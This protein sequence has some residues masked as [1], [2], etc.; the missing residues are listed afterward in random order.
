[1]ESQLLPVLPASTGLHLNDR[2]IIGI[3]S[4][5]LSVYM[6]EKFPGNYTSYVPASYVKYI[7][8][9]G[10]RV[11]PIK[12]NRT[13]SY[14]ENLVNSVNGILFP[15]GAASFTAIGGYSAAAWELYHHAILKN[16][17]GVYF[18]VWGTCLGFE[19]LTYLAA[20]REDIRTDCEADNVAMPLQFKPGYN[21]SRLYANASDAI[22]KI[23]TSENVTA[24]FH[25]F[26]ITEANLT[27]AKLD[28]DWRVTAVNKDTQGLEFVSSFEHKQYPIYGVQFHPEKNAYEWKRTNNNPHTANAILVQQYF[29]NFFVNEARKNSH[30]FPSPEEEDAALIY[31]YQATYTGQHGSAFEQCYFFTD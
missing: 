9:A 10:A 17:A 21:T 14:Y 23:L 4:Q 27:Q 8:A 29:A 22:L 12:I 24:N 3:L 1:M 30:Q 2:P 20:Q 5:E 31:N 26:C 13:A 15:G 19:L 18:P 25:H 11:V 28:S 16:Q 6:Q 7:E